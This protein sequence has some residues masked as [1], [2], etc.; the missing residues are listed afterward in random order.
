MPDESAPEKIALYSHELEAGDLVNQ[1]REAGIPAEMRG[2]SVSG[3]RAESPGQIEVVVS[4]KHAEQARQLMV[5]LRADAQQIDWSQIDT[6]DP[7]EVTESEA[8]LA[9]VRWEQV[10]MILLAIAFGLF[11]L[12]IGV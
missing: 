2:W 4:G 5:E 8:N 6:G 10:A 3:F 1:L 12:A 7:T 11:V 9:S